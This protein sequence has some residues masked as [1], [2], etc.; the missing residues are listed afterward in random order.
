MAEVIASVFACVGS[1]FSNTV[2]AFTIAV[3]HLWDEARR[4]VVRQAAAAAGLPPVSIVSM[5]TASAAHTVA[6]TALKASDLLLACDLRDEGSIIALIACRPGDMVQ[7]VESRAYPTIAGV[8][9]D[10]AISA[11]MLHAATAEPWD[12]DRVRH[13]LNLPDVRALLLMAGQARTWLN[14][15][16]VL[17]S[18]GVWPANTIEAE[19]IAFTYRGRPYQGVLNA[20]DLEQI[21]RNPCEQLRLAVAEIVQQ[22]V[23]H[24]RIAAVALSGDLAQMIAFQYAIAE[25]SGVDPSL[26]RHNGRTAGRNAACGA[27]LGTEGRV[28]L[29]AQLPC[30]IGVIAREYHTTR[31]QNYLALRKGASLPARWQLDEPFQIDEPTTNPFNLVVGLGDASDIDRCQVITC[32]IPLDAPLPAGTPCTFVFSVDETLRLTIEMMQGERRYGTTLDLKVALDAEHQP[33]QNV[34]TGGA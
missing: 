15:A 14:D 20:A 13:S 10:A 28:V 24:R 34:G 21:L 8:W 5:L 12:A 7:V 18:Q 4:T 19:E 27:L 2:R 26:V 17:Q 9:V 33:A 11:R 22:M 23:A 31:E 29:S 16:I 6:D 25:G 1:E 3:P 30:G 32:P